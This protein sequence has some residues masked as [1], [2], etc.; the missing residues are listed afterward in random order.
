MKQDGI[1]NKF[2]L[3]LIWLPFIYK[4]WNLNFFHK[5]FDYQL[6]G[7]SLKNLTF[8]LKSGMWG[9]NPEARGWNV[10]AVCLDFNLAERIWRKSPKCT[11]FGPITKRAKL[12]CVWGFFY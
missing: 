4:K 12:G 6:G 7:F 2:G 11:F 1:A 3:N 9:V 8:P 10:G 5:F